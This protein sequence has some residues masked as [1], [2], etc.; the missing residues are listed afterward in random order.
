MRCRVATWN[1]HSCVGP[2]GRYAPERVAGVLAALEADVIGLQEVD[3]RRPTADGGEVLAYL[4][5]QLGMHAVEGPN[6]HDHRGRYGNGLL[7]RF[8]VADF[9]LHSLAYGGREPRG[10]IEATLAGESG[11][12]RTFVTHLGLNYR[13][14]R[15]QVETLRAAARDGTTGGAMVL[16]GD[17]NEWFT[18]RLMRRAFT[19]EPFARMA[20]GRTFPSRW[21]WFP[22]DCVF[23]GPAPTELELRVVST[24]EARAA[25]DHLPLVAD[26]VWG[27]GV[28]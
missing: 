21:P 24:P 18:H 23:A 12:I 13:E 14:R 11:P 16:L 27:Q 25:S 7:S 20:S 3:W 5:E 1:I 10:A 19:P 22:L 17:M 8:S 4:A 6:L 9:R 2:D 15:K 26:I 28:D